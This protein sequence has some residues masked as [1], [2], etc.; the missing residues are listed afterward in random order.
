MPQTKSETRWTVDSPDDGY[1]DVITNTDVI[2][3]VSGGNQEQDM[4]AA[5]LI[6]RA[7]NAHRPLI[8]AGNAALCALECNPKFRENEPVIRDLRTALALA[9][10]T[11]GE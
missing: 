7:V 5:A 6:V 10:A 2:V 9:L 8:D 4:N 3:R 11:K 1:V